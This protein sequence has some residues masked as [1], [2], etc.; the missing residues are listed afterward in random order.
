MDQHIIAN[1]KLCYLRCTFNE[2]TEVTD[3]QNRV[4][5]GVLE[6][7]QYYEGS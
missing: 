2:L 6:I 3:G 5:Q 1:F 4:S 7:L